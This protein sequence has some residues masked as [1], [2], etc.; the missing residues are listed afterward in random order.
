MLEGYRALACK[1]GKSGYHISFMKDEDFVNK[2]DKNKHKEFSKDTIIIGG[3][4][5]FICHDVEIFHQKLED[6]CSIGIKKIFPHPSD[7]LFAAHK[8]R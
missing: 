8:H 3:N 7:V 5:P 6:L 4:W 2:V 1:L